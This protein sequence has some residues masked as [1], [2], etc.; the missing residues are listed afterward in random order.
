MYRGNVVLWVLG[1]V[2]QLQKLNV[3][4]QSYAYRV[5]LMVQPGHVTRSGRS[6]SPVRR[7]AVLRLRV[8]PLQSQIVAMVSTVWLWILLIQTL[9]VIL[10]ST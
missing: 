4:K 5:I 8:S 7:R 10:L 6:Y 3:I 2:R 1:L 9:W